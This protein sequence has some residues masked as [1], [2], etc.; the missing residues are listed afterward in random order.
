MS[1]THMHTFAR[2]EGCL[3]HS[4]SDT[5]H[6]HNGNCDLKT[7]ALL[8]LLMASGECFSI[9]F[10]LCP[11]NKWQLSEYNEGQKVETYTQ[12]EYVKI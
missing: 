3:C 11:Q 6:Y 7:S 1:E 8:I 12:P 10:A 5:Q 9:F 4:E 2:T